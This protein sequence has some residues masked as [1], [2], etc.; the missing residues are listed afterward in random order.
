MLFHDLSLEMQAK[1]H[2]SIRNVHNRIIDTSL[3]TETI[4][5]C[6]CSKQFKW[7]SMRYHAEDGN[8]QYF[9]YCMKCTQI[10][11]LASTTEEAIKLWN[12]E[13]LLLQE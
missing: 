11:Q 2:K 1:L 5:G 13:V 4:L 12:S 3:N 8:S 9:V 7:A 10:G 6:S